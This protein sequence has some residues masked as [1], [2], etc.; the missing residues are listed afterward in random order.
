MVNTVAVYLLYSYY[1]S[2]CMIAYDA[3]ICLVWYA[4]V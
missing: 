3:A 4:R 2:F 1:Y